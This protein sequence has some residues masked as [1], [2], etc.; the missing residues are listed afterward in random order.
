MEN[1]VV[2]MLMK[3]HQARFKIGPPLF[4]MTRQRLVT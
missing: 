2:M 3:A 4:R 1:P